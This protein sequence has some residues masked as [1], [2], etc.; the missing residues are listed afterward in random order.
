ML[1]KCEQIY[2]I[3]ICQKTQRLSKKKKHLPRFSFKELKS[4]SER[5]SYHKNPSNS[6]ITS[7]SNK[8]SK[9]Q[10]GKEASDKDSVSPIPLDRKTLFVLKNDRYI[11][12]KILTNGN[13]VSRFR[14]A[15]LISDVP[16]LILEGANIL[17][18]RAL[19]YRKHIPASFVVAS[20]DSDG[21]L[22]NSDYSD[23]GASVKEI[24]N[25]FVP[26]IGLQRSIYSKDNSISWR[27]FLTA[28]GFLLVRQ[29]V[30][31]P[32]IM[33]VA[34]IPLKYSDKGDKKDD[35]SETMF[36]K[37]PLEWEKD[38]ELKSKFTDKKG[39]YMNNFSVYLGH[40]P[41]ED[42]DSAFQ[43]YLQKRPDLE[44]LIFEFMQHLLLNKPD[45]V[46][47]CAA[48]FFSSK[49]T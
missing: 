38:M 21:N 17:L 30:G 3:E 22:C 34:Q 20:I 45:D 40:K 13:E 43:L 6:E 14:K 19:I 41:E 26:V 39:T 31:S 25:E 18:V 27:Y 24:C 37:R 15:W 11:Y 46:F 10:S 29:Q 47:V 2:A 7:L 49:P 44:K 16:T 33:K 23:L 28:E 8:L 48:H 42:I 9:R 32:V 12:T 4:E 36:K 35:I 1:P 5:M